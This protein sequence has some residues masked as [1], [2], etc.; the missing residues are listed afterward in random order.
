MPMYN[1]IEYSD[2]YLKTSAV[3][4]NTIKIILMITYKT[5]NHLNI[6]QK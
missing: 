2:N 4:G 1:L 6:K 5:L 3:Y